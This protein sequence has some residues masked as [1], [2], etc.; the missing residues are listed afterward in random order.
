MCQRSRLQFVFCL[1]ACR[2][3]T[4][5]SCVGAGVWTGTEKNVECCE[6]AWNFWP[7]WCRVT[8]VGVTDWFHFDFPWTA[9]WALQSWN[10]WW[11]LDSTLDSCTLNFPF[12]P[13]CS[14]L[15]SVTCRTSVITLEYKDGEVKAALVSIVSSVKRALKL[16]WIGWRKNRPLNH[17]QLFINSCSCYGPVQCGS[18]CCGSKFFNRPAQATAELTEKAAHLATTRPLMSCASMSDKSLTSVHPWPTICL[19]PGTSL[20]SAPVRTFH[21]GFS[22][23]TLST[24]SC[25]HTEDLSLLSSN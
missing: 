5:A 2:A 21:N 25:V 4:D 24:S 20:A 15:A 22:R 16:L 10:K 18:N 17:L 9:F 14:E 12:F 1:H 19:I 23:N 11:I 8:Q 7:F 6:T 13:L 3:N